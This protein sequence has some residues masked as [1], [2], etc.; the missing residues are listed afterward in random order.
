MSTEDV[1]KHITSSDDWGIAKFKLSN[2]SEIVTHFHFVAHE[3][4]SNSGEI[5]S[6]SGEELPPTN[7]W[8]LFLTLNSSKASSV[9]VE[10]TPNEFGKPGMVVVESKGYALTNKSTKTVS[11]FA[12][13]NMTVAKVFNLII[14]KKRDYY[15]FAPVGEG[16]RFWLYTIAFDFLRACFISV[17][18]ALEAQTAL[19]MYWPTPEGTAP[20]D[21]PMARGEFPKSED[22]ECSAIDCIIIAEV[23]FDSL[24]A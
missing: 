12:P 23:C 6:G 13:Q 14:Q 11:D 24:I 9:R 10:V 8:S 7:H 16:C 1:A 4:P 5:V 2:L 20:I 19:S 22:C 21:R 3:N 18:K 17:D 15:I